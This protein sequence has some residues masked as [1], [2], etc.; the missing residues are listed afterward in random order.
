[1]NERMNEPTEPLDSERN[2]HPM[3]IYGLYTLA[4]SY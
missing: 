1:M 3:N 4:K 2:T